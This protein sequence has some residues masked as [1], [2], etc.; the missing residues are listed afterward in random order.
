MVARGAITATAARSLSTTA[1][2][3]VAVFDRAI[4]KLRVVR[5]TT[6]MAAPGLAGVL[7]DLKV[8]IV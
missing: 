8:G 6:L 1:S 5:K 7:D 3:T 4:W 2:A